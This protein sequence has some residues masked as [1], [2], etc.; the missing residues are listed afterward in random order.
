M[1]TA[2]SMLQRSWKEKRTDCSTNI[3]K[4][5]SLELHSLATKMAGTLTFLLVSSQLQ[6]ALCRTFNIE[7]PQKINVLR[8]SC[9]T[10]PCSFD[11]ERRFENNLDDSCKAYWSDS[12]S[13]TT[14]NAKLKP[15]K[16]MTGDLTKKDCTTTFNNAS[17]LQSAKYYFRLECNNG[18]KY[19]F[20][21]TG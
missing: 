15:T 14:E 18:L 1:F 4:S 11:V 5:Y 6:G 3:M 10:I 13:F 12:P 20:K 2:V 19:T 8:G 7:M 17:Y 9:V 16:E 21:Q